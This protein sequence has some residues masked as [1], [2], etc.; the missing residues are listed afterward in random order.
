MCLILLEGWSERK[1]MLRFPR[2]FHADELWSSSRLSLPPFL[3]VC[4]VR[5][6]MKF[7]KPSFIS[8]GC[9][10][11]FNP[12]L[13]V[14]SGKDPRRHIW[15]NLRVRSL[16]AVCGLFVVTEQIKPHNTFVEVD[17]KHVCREVHS[18]ASSCPCRCVPWLTFKTDTE[19][20]L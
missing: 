6:R 1:T 13:V 14:C 2:S 3:F 8:F 7:L 20:K 5:T 11:M 10:N 18:T 12:K 19:F 15:A 4:H 9:I 17:W 16:A